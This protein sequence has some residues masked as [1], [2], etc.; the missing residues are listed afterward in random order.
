MA[1]SEQ[2]ALMEEKS[3]ARCRAGVQKTGD[4]AARERAADL[5]HASHRPSSVGLQRSSSGL[6]NLSASHSSTRAPP[7]TKPAGGPRAYPRRT[8]GL[9]TVEGRVEVIGDVA[10]AALYGSPRRRRAAFAILACSTG[11]PIASLIILA[12]RFSQS[13]ILRMWLPLVGT[14]LVVAASAFV[15]LRALLSH[16]R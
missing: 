11:L 13:G 15:L 12:A 6:W 14:L 10:R 16:R 3:A 1:R 5:L 4:A 7:A 8:E 9:Y 2:S